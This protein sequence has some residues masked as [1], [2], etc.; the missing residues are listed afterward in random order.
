[1]QLGGPSGGCIPAELFDTLVDYESLMSTGAIVGSGGM[2]AVDEDT[3][4]VDLASIL[5]SLFRVSLVEN[6]LFVELEQ[7]GC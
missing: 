7:K 2:V 6:V 4:M 3:C 5:C 1:M